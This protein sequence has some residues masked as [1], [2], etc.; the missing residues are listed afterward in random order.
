M[1][2]AATFELDDA[3]RSEK[4]TEANGYLHY[5]AMLSPVIAAALCIPLLPLIGALYLLVRLTSRGPGFYSQV[6]LGRN[7]KHFTIYK[8][9]SMVVNAESAT[10]PVWATKND[11][12]TTPIGKLLRDLHLDELPQIFNVVK[13]DMCFVGPRPERPEI[14][15][16]ITQR[17]PA[18]ADRLNVKPGITGMAQV[19]LPPDTCMESV[20]HKL[21][22]DLAYIKK[23]NFW[24]DTRIV[25]A[26]ALKMVPFAKKITQQLATCSDF[27]SYA[28][29][30]FELAPEAVLAKK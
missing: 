27:F 16:S 2:R 23:G 8:L 18:Y 28:R 25:A 6:R 9:R 26:T 10:G 15:A 4:R 3:P 12:R 30:R 11:P 29:E 7:G 13:G 1:I 14:A 5:K 17:L 20:R 19:H 24:L 22:Y 21:S